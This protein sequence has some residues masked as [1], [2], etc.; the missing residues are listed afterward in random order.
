M[1]CTPKLEGGRP[2]A[3][4]AGGIKLDSVQSTTERIVM[5]L[6]L[7]AQVLDALLDYIARMLTKVDLENVTTPDSD[8]SLAIT[9][10]ARVDLHYNPVTPDNVKGYIAFRELLRQA[11]LPPETSK[12]R[13]EDEQADIHA[14]Q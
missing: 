12:T 13:D 8:L 1:R 2:D 11:L 5:S 3:L 6:S 14:A 10:V 9:M 4:T 7:R